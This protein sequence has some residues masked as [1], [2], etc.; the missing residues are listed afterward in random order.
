MGLP[1]EKPRRATYAE[2]EAVPPSKVAEIIDGTLY[3]FPRPAPPHA[4]ATS[5]LNGQLMGPFAFGQRGPGGWRMLVEPELHLGPPEAEDDVVPD[6]AGWRIERLPRL[7]R[8]AYISV[9]PDWVCEVLSKGTE[10]IDRAE[11]MPIYAREGVKHAWLLHPI[12][13]TLEVYELDAARR[14]ILL[15]VHQGDARVR[16]PPFDEIELALPL[17]WPE[18]AFSVEDDDEEDTTPA[19][20]ATKPKRARAKPKRKG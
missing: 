12:R 5:A 10:R 3:S 18:E 7:P 13:Q 2:L 11:K 8:T 17:L 20:P 16:V 14:W 1:A 9:A 19:P 4:H 15:A 6:L